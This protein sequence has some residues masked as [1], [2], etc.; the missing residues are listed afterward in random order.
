MPALYEL[1]PFL[2]LDRRKD[3]DRVDLYLPDPP[4]P[5]SIPGAPVPKE[6]EPTPP[7]SNPTPP[8]K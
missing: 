7:P 4:A 1:S 8:E 5:Q 6:Y 2:Y 3:V